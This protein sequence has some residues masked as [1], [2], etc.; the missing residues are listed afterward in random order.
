MN[1]S[2]KEAIYMKK[3]LRI[4][5]IIAISMISYFLFYY[6]TSK[7]LAIHFQGVYAVMA[8]IFLLTFIGQTL[9]FMEV[10]IYY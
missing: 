8:P 1:T 6:V 2:S 10:V 7:F 3:T 5:H 9:I 4:L